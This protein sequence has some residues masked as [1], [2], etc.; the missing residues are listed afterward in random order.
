MSRGTSVH[1]HLEDE[2][3]ASIVIALVF[4][5][6]CAV[7]GSVVL[8]AASVQAKAVQTHREMQQAEFT[9]GSAAGFIG[10][11]LKYP[12][13][14]VYDDSDNLLSLAPVSGE[15]ND[16]PFFYVFW[17]AYGEKIAETYRNHASFEVENLKVQQTEVGT[18]FGRIVVT[19]NLDFEIDLS[20]EEDMSASSPYNMHVYIQSIPTFDIKGELKAVEYESPVITKAEGAKR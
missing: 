14:A 3:G 1:S 18:V 2:T 8:T 13:T 19:G 4:F 20:L 17:Q 6:I 12:L 11:Q 7:I 10:S 5:L 15:A 16:A 9:V